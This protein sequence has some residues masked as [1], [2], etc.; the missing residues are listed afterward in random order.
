MAIHVPSPADTARG[1][2][3]MVTAITVL[4]KKMKKAELR[5][6]CCPLRLHNKAKVNPK[7]KLLFLNPE[8]LI[9]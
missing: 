4:D 1:T 8:P 5:R 2:G 7:L 6:K 3:E 9:R